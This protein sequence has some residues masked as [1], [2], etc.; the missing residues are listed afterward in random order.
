MAQSQEYL[1]LLD[2]VKERI[3]ELIE[4]MKTLHIRKASAYSGVDNPDTWANFRNAEDYGISA[5]MGALVRKE[6][7]IARTKVLLRNPSTDP[8]DESIVDTWA[9]EAAYS[10]IAACLWREEEIVRV[11]WVAVEVEYRK[12]VEEAEK[13]AL[14]AF[15]GL[16]LEDKIE[17]TIKAFQ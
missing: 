10:L 14:A 4:E 1:D 2:R 7:K 6:D 17:V 15:D 13:Q 3:P 11:Q 16:K 12:K 9:D 5:L 8:G